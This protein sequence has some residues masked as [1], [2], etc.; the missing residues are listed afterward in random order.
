MTSQPTWGS[1]RAS[2]KPLIPT[3]W[4]ISSA[5]Y[6]LRKPSSVC[7]S[8][9]LHNLNSEPVTLESDFCVTRETLLTRGSVHSDI[10]ILIQ[11]PAIEITP[12]NKGR[13]RRCS[14]E[15]LSS[16]LTDPLWEFSSVFHSLNSTN[17]HRS[18]ESSLLD[19][20]YRVKWR[21]ESSWAEI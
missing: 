13:A 11:S 15:P 8:A 1:F 16:R 3:S 19:G 18:L 6:P 5:V 20:A 17:M 2:Q 7:S 14:T 21:T 10:R 4:S 9:R 12:K